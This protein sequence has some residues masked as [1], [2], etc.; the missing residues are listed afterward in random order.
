[1]SLLNK[2]IN[3]SLLQD[4][5]NSELA[6]ISYRA[7]NGKRQKARNFNEGMLN[8]G[9]INF[10]TP[11]S[12]ITKDMILDYQDE[13]QKK[14]YEDTAGN[15]LQYFPSEVTD[16]LTV[17]TPIQLA[18]LGREVT[19]EDINIEK[20]NLYKIHDDLN[21]QYKDIKMKEREKSNL[22]YDLAITEE[23]ILKYTNFITKAENRINEITPI[24]ADIA[25]ILKK[26]K[27][28]ITD[29]ENK[30]VSEKSKLE[31]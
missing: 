9:T 23:N 6:D 17:Y 13:Q 2:V 1:M 7:I 4:K 14:H 11:K 3:E 24:L 5:L 31:K 22:E 27:K 19:E 29:E 8:V 10:N 15:K 26:P 18:S 21:Q 30:K 20:Q 25:N 28:S 16:A 12:Q